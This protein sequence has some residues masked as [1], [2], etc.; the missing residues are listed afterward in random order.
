MRTTA[1]S[2]KPASCG[3]VTR[4]HVSALAYPR[5][6]LPS[7]NSPVPAQ[8]PAL[9][10]SSAVVPQVATL[11][12]PASI[13]SAPPVPAPSA[14][15]LLPKLPQIKLPHNLRRRL[16]T[17][18]D[19]IHLHASSASLSMLHGVY[20]SARVGYEMI[21]HHQLPGPEA[22]WVLPAVAL[23]NI[24]RDMTGLTL[25]LQHRKGQ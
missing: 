7:T 17:H 14:P 3:R 20:E 15:T 4:L 23:L 25:A 9:Q 19:F 12:A 21:A 6:M 16:F 24:T 1:S 13:T 2:T 11:Q 10:R 18:I 5:R 8:S 22:N